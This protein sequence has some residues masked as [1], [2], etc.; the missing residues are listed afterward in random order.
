LKL[1]FY[2]GVVQLQ[3]LLL[4][5]LILKLHT[6][7]QLE[8]GKKKLRCNF[9]LECIIEVVK[10]GMFIQVIQRNK[11]VH[12]GRKA[13]LLADSQL[14]RRR[15]INGVFLACAESGRVRVSGRCEKR[16][17]QSLVVRN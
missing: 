13:L 10:D 5:W 16:D 8:I 1:L 2:I 9:G 4:T 7:L 12:F 3:T 15:S 14:G 11:V 6:Q 17:C